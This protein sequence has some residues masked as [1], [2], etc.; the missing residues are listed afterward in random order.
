MKLYQ[1]LKLLNTIG[2]S[3]EFCDEKYLKSRL[4]GCF[5]FEKYIE[6]YNL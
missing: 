5:W 2:K 6:K 4:E 1:V 3:L